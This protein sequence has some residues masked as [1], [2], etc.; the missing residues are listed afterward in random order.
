MD[1]RLVATDRHGGQQPFGIHLA[2]SGAEGGRRRI[3]IKRLAVILSALQSLEQ[4]DSEQF[5]KCTMETAEMFVH[6]CSCMALHTCKPAPINYWFMVLRYS[7]RDFPA[8][9]RSAGESK[10]A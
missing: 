2:L 1:G 9:R 3:P 5:G 4:V 10:Q 7:H 6:H 8:S